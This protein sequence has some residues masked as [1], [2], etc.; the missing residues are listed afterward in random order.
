MALIEKQ[1]EGQQGQEVGR[2]GD[3]RDSG[4]D[5]TAD[6][7]N[8]LEESALRYRSPEGEREKGKAVLCTIRS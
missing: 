8:C 6:Y 7:K 1:S 2:C 4:R 5:K 3:K